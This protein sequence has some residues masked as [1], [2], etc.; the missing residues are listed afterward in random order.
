[1]NWKSFNLSSAYI[2]LM[3]LIGGCGV[4]SF[5]GA[6]IGP[7]V[8]TI[9]IGTFFSNAPLGPSNMSTLFTEKLRDFYQQNTSLVLVQEE[10]D[11]QIEG[12]IEDYTLKPIAPSS[13][14]NTGGID[15]SSLTRINITVSVSY[16]NSKDDAY[17]FENKNFSFF[18][19]F[20]QNSE[21]L[22]S[23]EQ[24]FLNEIFDQIIL[25]IFNNS[26]ANW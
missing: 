4:Y 1:M 6:S 22:E 8:K 21:D 3:V 13:A 7:D 10:G 11:L 19:D 25:D 2:S 18:R 23:N 12:F 16:Y 9:S 5:S 24:E 15:F 20:D 14:N 17:N 26:V